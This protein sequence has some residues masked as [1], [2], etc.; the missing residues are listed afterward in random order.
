[1]LQSNKGVWLYI[2]YYYTT[3][4]CYS[5]NG[6]GGRAL[7]KVCQNLRFKCTIAMVSVVR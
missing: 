4:E 5:I 3:K 2:F 7:A 6:G 1:M